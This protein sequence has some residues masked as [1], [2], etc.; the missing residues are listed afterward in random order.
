VIVTDEG[1]FQAVLLI[2]YPWI[3]REALFLNGNSGV[4]HLQVTFR[5]WDIVLFLSMHYIVTHFHIDS[6]N[7]NLIQFPFPRPYP[8]ILN[9]KSKKLPTLSY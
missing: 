1:W 6:T 8:S 9:P 7:L 3:K 4:S 5:D 2:F